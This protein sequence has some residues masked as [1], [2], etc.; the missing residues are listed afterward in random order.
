MENISITTTVYPITYI[1]Q[2]LYGEY[3]NITSIYPNGV[4]ASNYELTDKQ[5]ND[6]SKTNLLIYNGLR[7]NN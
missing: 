5:I 2:T 7:R 1:I 3:G 4:D 6:F